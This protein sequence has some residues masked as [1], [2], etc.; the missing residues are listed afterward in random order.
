MAK[1]IE[2]TESKVDKMSNLVEDMLLAGGE[3]MHCLTKLSD[4]MYGER[5]GNTGGGGMSGNRG[6][7]VD[8]SRYAGMS[9][10]RMSDD[11][12]DDDDWRMMR[13]MIG[14]RRGRRNYRR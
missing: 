11:Y 14:E 2:I 12:D 9:G 3:L 7:Y 5:G 1:V 10:N 6:S 4:E 8:R 13:E